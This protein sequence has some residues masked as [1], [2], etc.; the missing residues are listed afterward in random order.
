MDA[1]FL[2]SLVLPARFDA[3]I[4]NFAKPGKLSFSIARA[5]SA[6]QRL[7]VLPFFRSVGVQ[8]SATIATDH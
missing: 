7:V 5:Y 3:I 2:A 8:L 1:F 6:G 4:P